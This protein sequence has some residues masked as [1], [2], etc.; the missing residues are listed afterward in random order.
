MYVCACVFVYV[1][2]GQG[3]CTVRVSLGNVCVCIEVCISIS[4]EK[5]GHRLATL[6]HTI[7]NQFFPQCTV[8]SRKA[9]LRVI[10]IS[11]TVRTYSPGQLATPI[12]VTFYSSPSF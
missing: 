1:C 5:R 2:K 11:P 8:C 4:L 6:R 9:Q 7:L 10:K 3:E 12:L